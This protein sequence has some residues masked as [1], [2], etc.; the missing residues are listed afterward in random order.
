VQRALSN[1]RDPVNHLAIW[2]K[3][4]K[5]HSGPA[6]PAPGWL[7]NPGENFVVADLE[8]RMT[9]RAYDHLLPL[10]IGDAAP[11]G[12]RLKLDHRAPMALTIGN[13]LDVAE[14]SFNRYTIAYARGDTSLVG[15]PAFI[16]RGFRHRNFICRA[17]SK[18][19]SLA[20]L[21]GKRV[22]TNAW[23]DTG[24]TWARA[25]MRDAGVGV[26][27]VQWV[28]GTL[29]ANT[30]NKP[31]SPNDA[32]PPA[33]AR[34]L[35][36]SENLLAEMEAGR[37]DAF[38]TAFAPEPVFQ[39][40][41][42][43]RRLV[44]DYRAAEGEYHRRTG[45]YPA[46]HIVAARREFA[47]QHPKAMLAIYDALRHSFDLWATKVKC[48]AEA[49]PYAMAD[50]ETMLHDFAGDTPPF[51]MESPAHQKMVAAMC[52]E[53]HAQGLVAKPA[54]PEELFAGFNELHRAAAA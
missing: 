24:T 10:F 25:A 23:P 37:L 52:H 22:G 54:R 9:L 35:S 50:F 19:T 48:F 28:L 20:E 5:G 46:F 31:P 13:D 33:S 43:L 11:K 51:G 27:D 47:M 41:G 42:W 4:G 12:V 45:V 44:R 2:A 14:V 34:I 49:T 8:V 6:R 32:Q 1:L 53:Q 26:N 29:D 21:R 36:G 38:Y 30:P 3:L 39:K 17:D 18:L 16:L 15:M 40:G 7:F